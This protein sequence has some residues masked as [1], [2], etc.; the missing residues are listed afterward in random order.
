MTSVIESV[1]R[2][3]TKDGVK[4]LKFFNR[5]RETVLLIPNDLSTG[6]GEDNS[7]NDSCDSDYV[8]TSKS[9]SESDSDHSDNSEGTNNSG[10]MMIPTATSKKLRK[11]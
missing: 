2:C 10:M 7:E 11:T 3:A 1:E 8:P 6:V 5:K 9:E 4:T